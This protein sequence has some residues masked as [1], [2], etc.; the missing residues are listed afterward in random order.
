MNVGNSIWSTYGWSTI[1]SHSIR[2][3]GITSLLVSGVDPSV[4]NKMGRW[5]SEAYLRYWHTV[6]EVFHPH[7]S[8]L[9][10]KN[11]DIC[12]CS[13]LTF[14]F[15]VGVSFGSVHAS[16][17]FHCLDACWSP[18]LPTTADSR[19][20]LLLGIIIY[21]IYITPALLL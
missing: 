14:R 15:A 7:T 4:V 20:V 6:E 11:F 16:D 1:T 18:A 5:S 17:S 3:G 21:F 8:N 13:S 2:T 10:F 12:H 9:P 19:L